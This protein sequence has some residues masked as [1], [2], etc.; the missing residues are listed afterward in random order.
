MCMDGWCAVFFY[1]LRATKANSFRVLWSSP[2][3]WEMETTVCYHN[4]FI[5]DELYLFV[6][7]AQGFPSASTTSASDELTP[8]YSF[9][10]LLSQLLNSIPI[11]ILQN[12]L[13]PSFFHVPLFNDIIRSMC[14]IPCITPIPPLPHHRNIHHQ[15]RSSLQKASPFIPLFASFLV[16]KKRRSAR[17]WMRCKFAEGRALG[18]AFVDRLDTRNARPFC[19]R[20]YLAPSAV[21]I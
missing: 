2:K 14:L 13:L 20:R 9:Y 11:P 8:S 7:D 17:H 4:S 10:I 18:Y 3:R 5:G 6:L 16:V 15:I 19:G 1:V 12:Q 21:I